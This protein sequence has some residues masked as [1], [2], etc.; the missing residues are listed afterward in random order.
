MKIN[1]SYDV[2]SLWIG[3]LLEEVESYFTRRCGPQN[4]VSARPTSLRRPIRVVNRLPQSSCSPDVA[5]GE[6]KSGP[7]LSF[8][9]CP[10]YRL[11]SFRRLSVACIPSAVA[12]GRVVCPPI[13]SP[14]PP[15]HLR[16]SFSTSS[17]LVLARRCG[18]P[19]ITHPMPNY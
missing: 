17:L 8:T 19:K 11:C 16:R 18:S 14:P 4:K 9:R 1:P 3:P 12:G 5:A 7:D 6:I 13:H 15:D 10:N 2:F